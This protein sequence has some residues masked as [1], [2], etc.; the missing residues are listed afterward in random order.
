MLI[1][2]MQISLGDI[3]VFDYLDQVTA[4]A[5]VPPFPE[6]LGALMERVKNYPKLKEY[7]ANRK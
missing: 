6:K 5:T 7:L 1:L 4:L 2:I 3:K